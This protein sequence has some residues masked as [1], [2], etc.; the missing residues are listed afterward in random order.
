[1][2]FKGIQPVQDFLSGRDH[3]L[4]LPIPLQTGQQRPELRAYSA[5][6]GDDALILVD[7]VAQAAHQIEL[8]LQI[9]RAHVHARIRQNFDRHGITLAVNGEPGLILPRKGQWP[10]RAA[11]VIHQARNRFR[12][13]IP[14]IPHSPVQAGMT[15]YFPVRRLR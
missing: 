10:D 5:Q 1:M 8:L 6:F 7:E 3:V 14:H 2:F 12:R 9:R 11:L 15:A 13:P 4:R